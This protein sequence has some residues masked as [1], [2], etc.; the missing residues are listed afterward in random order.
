MLQSS[1]LNYV[2]ELLLAPVPLLPE[3]SLLKRRV[4]V[5]SADRRRTRRIA[6]CESPAFVAQKASVVVVSGRLAAGKST[7]FSINGQDFSFDGDTWMFGE[8]RLGSFATV[9]I[10]NTRDGLYAKKIVAN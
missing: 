6:G 5:R 2:I 7:P 8:V 10:V 4:P 3:G 9:N 1:A